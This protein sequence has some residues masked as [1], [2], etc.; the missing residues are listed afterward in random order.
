MSRTSDIADV[1]VT[2]EKYIRG[3]GTGDADLLRSIFH[4]DA[5]MMGA[6]GDKYMEGTPESF[7]KTIEEAPPLSEGDS[8]Y[9]AEIVDIQIFGK[10]AIATISEEGFFGMGFVD[11]F[12]L[13]K[14]DDAWVITSKIF[15][16]D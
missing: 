6:L 9:H 16:R 11:S 8:N 4:K 1:R 2:I 3:S 7:F 10:A 15:N 13:L 14:K 5:I 12:H